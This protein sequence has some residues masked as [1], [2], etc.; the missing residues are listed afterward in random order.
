MRES[1]VEIAG[2]SEDDPK[3]IGEREDFREYL[4]YTDALVSHRNTLKLKQKEVAREMGTSQSAVSE[5]ERS[6]SDPRISTLMRYARALGVPLKF[7]FPAVKGELSVALEP[8]QESVTL[9]ADSGYRSIPG[10]SFGG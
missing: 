9:P 7:R 6:D 3:V 5:L 10:A 1:I 2:Y 4:K 8:V